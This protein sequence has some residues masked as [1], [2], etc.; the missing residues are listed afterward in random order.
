MVELRQYTLKPGQRDVL[1]QVFERHFIEPQESAGACVIG[2]FRDLDAPDRFVWL[3]GYRDMP[4]RKLAL[5]A[6]YGGEV[7]ARHRDAANQTMLDSD[8]VLLLRPT[9]PGS[10][11][12]IARRQ[13]PVPVGQKSL[14]GAI[15]CPLDA[16]A[17]ASL[18]E[19]VEQELPQTLAEVGGTLLATLLTE[20]SE[21]NYPRL[22]V[23]EGENVLAWFARFPGED[24]H[25]RYLDEIER[26]PGWRAAP[27]SQIL[28]LAPAGRSRLV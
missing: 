2:H 26:W 11:F 28:R 24:S 14:I 6:F 27:G 21:N 22:P 17:A 3:R 25:R 4:S 5:E 9:R 8:D 15:V 18:L 12:K 16:P 10:G 13:Q 23:R 7:W 20:P 1:I 19:F